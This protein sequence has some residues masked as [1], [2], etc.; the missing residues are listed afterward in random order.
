MPRVALG[1]A[2]DGAPWQGW[3]TQP[4]GLTVQDTLESALGQFLAHPAST[5]CAGRTDTGVH[6][7]E[8]VVHVDT[9]AQRQPESWVR[10][11]NALL[12]SSVAVQWASVV[13][14]DFHARFSALSRTYVYLVRQARVRSPMMHGRAGW[15]YR[16]LS[17]EPMQRAAACLLGEHDFSAFR[18]SQCQ[19]ASPVRTLYRLDI[20]LQG[21]FFVFVFRANAFLHHMV[22]NLMGALLYIGQGRQEPAWVDTLLQR[23]DRRL[24]APTFSPAG[25]YLAGVEYPARFGLPR[26]DLNELL[27]THMLPVVRFER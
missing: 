15:V 9:A 26:A 24:S 5:I 16:P 3:Q 14:D 8:Q 20:E 7:L 27:A 17:L 18:S 10:G 23:R 6:A 1:L 11:L 2:Y 25:L 12:P 4:G 21:E 19:A 13:D 22:R